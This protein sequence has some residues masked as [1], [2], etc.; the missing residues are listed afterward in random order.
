[1]ILYNT[2]QTKKISLYGEIYDSIADAARTRNCSRSNIQRLLRSYP[3]DCFII[4][5]N[6]K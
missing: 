2:G 1:M 3:N 5:R 4:L 6:E